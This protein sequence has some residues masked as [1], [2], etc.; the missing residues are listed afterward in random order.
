MTLKDQMHADLTDAMK[1]RDELRLASLRMAL[2]AVTN[3]EVSGKQARVLSDADVV[4]V[5]GR[6][7]KKRRE[8]AQAFADAG[9]PDRADR[10]L[11]EAE[12]LQSY[13]PSQLTD[14]E[15]VELVRAAVQESGAAEPRQMGQVMKLVQPRVAGRADGS[16]VAGEV[17]RQLSAG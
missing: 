9:R 7:I 6:E 13:L 12:V 8:A 5:V 10:E 4:T 1:A 15:L 2:T 3:E 17:K 16:R 14:D 11:A